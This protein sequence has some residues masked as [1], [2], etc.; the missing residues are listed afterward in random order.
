MQAIALPGSSPT[1][2]FACPIC[3]KLSC[4][5]KL[6]CVLNCRSTFSSGVSPSTSSNAMLT[7][8]SRLSPSP[9]P[10]LPLSLPLIDVIELRRSRFSSPPPPPPPPSPP[11][12][13]PGSSLFF[14]FCNMDPPPPQ[15]KEE[16]ATTAGDT[17]AVEEADGA[18]DADARLVAM[19]TRRRRSRWSSFSLDVE[20]DAMLTRRSRCLFCIA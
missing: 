1:V 10:P 16:G 8:R 15:G 6:C 7:R 3:F 4:F 18:E 11:P 14:I 12:P 9:P 19:L 20:E 2:L 17:G 13:P 5:F